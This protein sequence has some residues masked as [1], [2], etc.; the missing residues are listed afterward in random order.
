MPRSLKQS[1]RNSGRQ[2]A[3]RAWNLSTSLPPYLGQ[4]RTRQNKKKACPRDRGRQQAQRSSGTC[5]SGG[6]HASSDT[7][8]R[9]QIQTKK[10]PWPVEAARAAAL[11]R[12]PR[13]TEGRR[14]GSRGGGAETEDLFKVSRTL[15]LM[16]K[17]HVVFMTNLKGCLKPKVWVVLSIPNSHLGMAVPWM[18]MISDGLFGWNVAFHKYSID[19]FICC[20]CSICFSLAKTQHKLSQ[21]QK[22]YYVHHLELTMMATPMSPETFSLGD[23]YPCR[24]KKAP[25]CLQ[26][27]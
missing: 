4:A 8:T 25:A 18:L 6:A 21:D 11:S 22:P 3:L 1:S 15:R 20:H 13:R 9:P 14:R 26:R 19:L 27:A 7:Y 17:G 12:P 5:R 10:P 24:W 2:D 16:H 23:A